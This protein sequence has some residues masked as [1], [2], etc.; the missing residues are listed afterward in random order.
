[1]AAL[2]EMLTSGVVHAEP[3]GVA[4][5]TLRSAIKT[6]AGFVDQLI[7]NQY[8]AFAEE[9][10][11]FDVDFGRLERVVRLKAQ[12]KQRPATMRSVANSRV[13]LAQEGEKQSA[14]V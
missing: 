9:V 14:T 12:T 8:L 5:D 1:L 11:T 2:F 13:S 4:L 6:K 7:R 3:K 10:A